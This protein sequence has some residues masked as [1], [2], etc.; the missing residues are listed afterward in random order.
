MQKCIVIADDDP[1]I[2]QLVKMRLS[3]AHYTVVATNDAVAA[4]AMV[5]SKDP[6]AVILDVQMPG[7]GGL[8]AL[9][10]IK[11]DPKTSKLPVM[12]LTGERN[13]ETVMM[14]MEGGADDYMVKPF[15]PD[16]LLE[17]ISRL[18]NKAAKPASSVAWEI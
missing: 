10:Q 5:K 12:I 9:S 14:A 7:G 11:A 2:I 1:N 15:L 13:A 17:R 16:V 8:S 6:V 3:M 18:V 4:V